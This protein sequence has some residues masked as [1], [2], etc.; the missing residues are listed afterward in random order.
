MKRIFIGCLLALVAS[1]ALVAVI[2]YD[3]GY[4]LVSIGY[5]T[6]E[7]TLVV[8]LVALLLLVLLVYGTITL[9]R[10]TFTSSS[11]FGS[12]F[13][14]LG[15]RRSEKKAAKGMI[16][17]IEGNWSRANKALAK[18]A[19]HSD[20]P[21]ISFLF[22]ARASNTLGDTQAAIDYLRQAEQTVAGSGLAVGLTQAELQLENKNYELALATLKRLRSK[23][24]K[25]A[26]AIKMLK[27]AFIGLNDWGG[28]IDLLPDLRKYKVLE[29]QEL[30]SLELMA[31]RSQLQEAARLK[32]NPV[33]ALHDVWKKLPRDMVRDGELVAIYCGRLMILGDEVAAEKIIRNQLKRD[34]NKVLV[35]LY[36]RVR[37]ADIPR[38]L[39]EAEAWLK[40]RNNDAALFLC[41]GR[42]SLRNKLWGKARDYFES[43]LKLELNAEACGELGRLYAHLG[44][45]EKSSDFFQQGLLLDLNGLP[46]LPMP[47]KAVKS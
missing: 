20:K 3:P 24:P 34:W 12:W 37:G 27:Q 23:A 6:L 7:S 18:S 21:L 14:D 10:R 13:S 38:Q 35:D 46:E 33:E 15:S 44:E 42:L 40:K 39:V 1:A 11:N 25:N 19:Q 30:V 36:G 26:R 4:V 16:D 31:A 28:V 17:F 22:A 47:D 9:V 29:K 32:V 41:L 5:Y 45:H 8:S 43:S 2:E